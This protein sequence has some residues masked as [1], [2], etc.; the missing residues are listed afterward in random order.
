MSTLTIQ[1]PDSLARQLRE[2]AAKEGV[3]VD[4]LLSSAAAE[5]LSALMTV[6]HLRERA[7]RAKRDDFVAFLDASPNVPPMDGDGL[8]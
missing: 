8:R 7:V 2:C 6:D 1:M 3:T 5:K 4:Q